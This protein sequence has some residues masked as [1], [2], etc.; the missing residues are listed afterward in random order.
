ML[1]LLAI[2]LATVFSSLKP[3]VGAPVLDQSWTDTSRWTATS[4]VVGD[5]GFTAQTFTTGF[6]GTISTVEIY[7]QRQHIGQINPASLAVSI[8][9][10]SEGIPS[11]ELANRVVPNGE[12]PPRNQPDWL[13]VDFSDAGL[14]TSAGQ[15]Y[16]IVFS[17]E[18][19]TWYDWLG[20]R[21]EP[22]YSRG[23]VLTYTYAAND[24]HAPLAAR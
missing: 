12:V 22:Y 9:S 11:T 10:V 20:S 21:G 5:W 1:R 13:V 7:V 8:W 15:E 16:A 2:F 18:G 3:A 19:Q 17:S 6:S 23:R 14:Y 24:W 4:S